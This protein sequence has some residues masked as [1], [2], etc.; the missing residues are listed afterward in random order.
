MPR[1]ELADHEQAGQEIQVA[2]DRRLAHPQGSGG[3]GRR[4]VTAV[5]VSG[6]G[7]CADLGQAESGEGNDLEPACERLGGLAEE[8]GRGAAKDQESRRQRPPIRQD[9]QD[10]K[11]VRS[12]RDLVY[13]DH[14]AEAR[15]RGH[16]LGQA[17]QARRILQAG[18]LP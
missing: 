6:D 13:D 15:Q 18:S 3:R 4:K 1:L 11:Q 5:P 14:A 12:P 10:R 8:I 7:L 17:R 16:R 2:P 9:A